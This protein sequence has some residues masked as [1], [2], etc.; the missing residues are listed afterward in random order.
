M[1]SCIKICNNQHCKKE[2]GT[3]WMSKSSNQQSKQ[4]Y[5]ISFQCILMSTLVT[6]EQEFFSIFSCFCVVCIHGRVL[7]L[8]HFRQYYIY[9]ENKIWHYG[10]SQIY[11]YGR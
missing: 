10:I 4:H 2:G 9:V 1:S 3:Y 5:G 8:K 6:V 7:Y 11:P